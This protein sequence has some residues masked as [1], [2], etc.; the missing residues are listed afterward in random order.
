MDP[1]MFDE[2]CH[3][4]ETLSTVV[5]FIWLFLWVTLFVDDQSGL[6]FESLPTYVTLKGILWTVK[7]L[8]SNKICLPL[9][10]SSTFVAFVRFCVCQSSLMPQKLWSVMVGFSVLIIFALLCPGLSS[11]TVIKVKALKEVLTALITSSREWKSINVHKFIIF[12]QLFWRLLGCFLL[13]RW[14]LP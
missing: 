10:G 13:Y 1:L 7:S 2:I 4:T 12:T 3:L 11:P 8:M 5:T 9:E 14:H 6:L